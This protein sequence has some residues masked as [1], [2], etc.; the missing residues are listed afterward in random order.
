MKSFTPFFLF[1]QLS[2]F[3]QFFKSQRERERDYFWYKKIEIIFFLF[4]WVNPWTT[5][6]CTHCFNF[7][8]IQSFSDFILPKTRKSEVEARNKSSSCLSFPHFLSFPRRLHPNTHYSRHYFPSILFFFVLC[9]PTLYNKNMI[10]INRNC[11][12]SK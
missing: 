6:S 9:S 5:P 4:A 11:Q 10:D 7:S 2:F 1:H 3:R 12:V 8:H